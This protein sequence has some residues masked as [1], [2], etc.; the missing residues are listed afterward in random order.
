M[1]KIY[2]K[3]YEA[4]LKAPL[5]NAFYKKEPWGF[6]KALEISTRTHSVLPNCT[7]Y[8]HGRWLEIGNFEKGDEYP[9]LCL[10]DAHSYYGYPDGY[11]RSQTP[12]VGD[13]AC[14]KGG[15]YG[16][17]G[18]VEE[19]EKNGRITVSMSQYGGNPV[20]YLREIDPPYNYQ[21]RDYMKFQGF[22]RCPYV[23]DNPV[24]TDE[25]IKQLAEEVIAGK[26]GNGQTRYRK[27]T[28]AGYDYQKVQAKVNEILH[29]Q[30][31]GLK[32]GDTVKIVNYGNSQA[33]GL[34]HKAYG[35]GWTRKVLKVFPT[36]E[37]PYQVGNEK[38]TTGF[39]KKGALKK[40]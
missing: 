13:I 25:L 38:G 2:V 40:V 32:V 7:G 33:N 21:G 39:Y 30:N 11:E 20:F 10:G 8:G 28:E 27:L 16:H 3:D 22:I 12:R 5:D 31:E 14:W 29:A 36:H 19:V 6:N 37:Y 23:M 17:I 1:K 26:W 18:V 35:Y 24:M 15:T 9:K 4:R 34:G